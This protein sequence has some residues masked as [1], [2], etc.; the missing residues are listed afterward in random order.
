MHV[1]YPEL[2]KFGFG[3]P[4]ISYCWESLIHGS[5]GKTSKACGSRKLKQY[6]VPYCLL[7]R[8]KTGWSREDVRSRPVKA[9]TREAKVVVFSWLATRRKKFKPWC[10]YQPWNTGQCWDEQLILELVQV[11]RT[12]IFLLERDQLRSTAR[13]NFQQLQPVMA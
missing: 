5:S 13:S 6:R 1:E 3:Y 9:W 7:S 2:L 10:T 12:L 8:A 4:L 11:T